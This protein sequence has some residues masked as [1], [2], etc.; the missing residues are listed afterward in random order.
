[1]SDSS[2]LPRIQSVFYAVF[3]VDKGPK[4]E[5]Q[6]P[7]GL[8]STSRIPNTAGPGVATSPV[9]LPPTPGQS[10]LR[11]SRQYSVP[12]PKE[13]TAIRS[14]SVSVPPTPLFSFEDISNYVIPNNEFC[15]RIVVCSARGYRIIGFPVLL[16]GKYK[17]NFFRFNLC[18]VFTQFADYKAYEP[19]V[20]KIARVLT[21]CEVSNVISRKN[22]YTD[23]VHRK[24]LISCQI[25]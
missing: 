1:M 24:S 7:D 25:A 10:P 19:V 11:E 22:I 8:I 5:Y 15:N 3:D 13:S 12:S 16:R 17:R 21:S 6:V 23:A 20:R 14:P 18:F 4:I 9:P 2:F